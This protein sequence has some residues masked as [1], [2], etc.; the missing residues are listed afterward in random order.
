[1]RHSFAAKLCL[2]SVSMSSEVQPRPDDSPNTSGGSSDA[3]Q[4]EAAPSE[5]SGPEQRDQTQ[6]KKKEAKISSKTA[7]KLSTSA[8]RI[9]KE[10]AEITLD[11]PPNCRMSMLKG[12]LVT[13]GLSSA[14]VGNPQS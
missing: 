9:Q 8:K 10:L 11:P 13:N 4:R 3:E 7:A 14:V 5:Q 12:A 6:P 1:M 2:E